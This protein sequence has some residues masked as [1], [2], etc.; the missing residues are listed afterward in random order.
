MGKI[1]EKDKEE[2]VKAI[3]KEIFEA[4]CVTVTKEGYDTDK[5]GKITSVPTHKHEKLFLPAANVNF[6]NYLEGALRGVQGNTDILRER[7]SVLESNTTEALKRIEERQ[8][9]LIKYI[10]GVQKLLV[11]I[12]QL[13]MNDEGIDAQ[14]LRQD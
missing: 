11:H 14:A 4:L 7:I 5:N 12:K 1:R 8:Q 9:E 13:K 3:T 2:L 6:M 10:G